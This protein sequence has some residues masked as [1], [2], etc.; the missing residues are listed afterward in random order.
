MVRDRPY[1]SME[2]YYE[3]LGTRGRPIEWAYPRPPT[4]PLTPKL[5]GQKVPSLK[6]SQMAGYQRKCLCSTFRNI[7][8]GCEVMP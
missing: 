4:P 5:G 7:L 2:S 6:L 1:V 8:A 3:L